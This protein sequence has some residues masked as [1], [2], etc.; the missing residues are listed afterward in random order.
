MSNININELLEKYWAA[1]TSLEEEK[2]IRQYYKNGMVPEVPEN[3][4]FEYFEEVQNQELKG[5]IKMSPPKAK[6]FN[7]RVLLSIAASLLILSAAFFSLQYNT[8]NNH[9]EITNPDE[10]LEMTLAALSIMNR[11]INTGEVIV[12]ENMKKFD[13][14][15]IIKL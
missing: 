10:A 13:K 9:R 2:I 15:K 14:T 1:E 7:F 11:S 4:L 12:K 8:N 6:I 3:A 5:A